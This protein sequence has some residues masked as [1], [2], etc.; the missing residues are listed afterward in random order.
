MDDDDDAG[1][2]SMMSARTMA[3]AQVVPDLG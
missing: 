3:C 1:V 2:R